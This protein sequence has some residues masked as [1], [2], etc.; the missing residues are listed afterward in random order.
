VY[1]TVDP[2]GQDPTMAVPETV[3]LT[4]WRQRK[5]PGHVMGGTR[6]EPSLWRALPVVLG[7]DVAAWRRMT[8]AAIASRLE[9]AR[10][11]RREDGLHARV[12]RLQER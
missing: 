5:M 6:L 8:V 10:P 12:L 7:D 1:Y 4:R 2:T 11:S 3:V 9:A